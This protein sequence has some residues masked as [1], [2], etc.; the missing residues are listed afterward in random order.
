MFMNILSNV[1]KPLVEPA[2]GKILQNVAINA[3][4]DNTD[5]ITESAGNMFRDSSSEL[6]AKVITESLKN[7]NSNSEKESNK[8]TDMN[9]DLYTMAQNIK[10][11]KN[12]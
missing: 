8:T 12:F 3:L 10:F 6:A 4:L 11:D 5:K 7:L 2:A 1:V 9:I